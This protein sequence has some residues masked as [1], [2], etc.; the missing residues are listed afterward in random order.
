MLATSIETRKFVL[1]TED[2]KE[3]IRC[4]ITE[5]INDIM[6]VRETL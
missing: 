2:A 4:T 6:K 1:D 5:I 3:K